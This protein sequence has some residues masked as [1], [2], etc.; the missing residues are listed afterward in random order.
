MS[1]FCPSPPVNFKVKGVADQFTKEDMEGITAQLE[2]T[3]GAYFNR[4][5]FR[6]NVTRLM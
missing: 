2:K 5:T 6:M 1:T 3:F 4:E